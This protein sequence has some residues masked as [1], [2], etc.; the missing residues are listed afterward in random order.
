M[1]LS[2]DIKSPRISRAFTPRHRI[3]TT[4]SKPRLSYFPDYKPHNFSDSNE[5][6]K[7]CKELN[8]LHRYLLNIKPTRIKSR[9]IN[10]DKGNE[11]DTL[12]DKDSES[13]I[14]QPK[15]DFDVKVNC[16]D[17]TMNSEGGKKLEV[18]HTD[19]FLNKSKDKDRKLHGKMVKKPIIMRKKQNYCSY[20]R[21]RQKDTVDIRNFDSFVISNIERNSGRKYDL[22][23]MR[24]RNNFGSKML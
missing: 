20:L 4:V 12:E 18:K 21:Q 17:K 14:L 8:S 23:S 9:Y 22:S 16:V 1:K 3:A 7:T 2:I 5:V 6:L 15:L 24:V 19:I 10:K 11:V 13:E